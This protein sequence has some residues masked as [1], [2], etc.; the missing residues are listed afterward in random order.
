[1]DK[2]AVCEPG[3]V[4]ASD[5]SVPATP[6]LDLV[7][8]MAGDDKTAS[9]RAAAEVQRRWNA[10]AGFRESTWSS[11]DS[12]QS[13]PSEWPFDLAA[14]DDARQYLSVLTL[15]NELSVLQR[16]DVHPAEVFL[17]N[18]GPVRIYD[19]LNADDNR[20]HSEWADDEPQPEGAE[21]LS[22]WSERTLF[23]EHARVL[24]E[25]L[26]LAGWMRHDLLQEC[27]EH[28]VL[29]AA[30]LEGP[31]TLESFLAEHTGTHHHLPL[32]AGPQ[33]P[34][35]AIAIA[36]GRPGNPPTRAMINASH[37]QTGAELA[38]ET[39]R[40]TRE[41]PP[42]D[43][44]EVREWS[45]DRLRSSH[46][47]MQSFVE[48]LTA[49]LGVHRLAEDHVVRL[50]GRAVSPSLRGWVLHHLISRVRFPEWE[51][52]TLTLAGAQITFKA[53]H[54]GAIATVDAAGTRKEFFTDS[55]PA[56]LV[57]LESP[58]ALTHLAKMRVG[59]DRIGQHLSAGRAIPSRREVRGIDPRHSRRDGRETNPGDQRR[60]R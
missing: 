48:F 39:D 30:Q 54:D 10:A 40:I 42:L 36:L 50:N 52:G 1:M 28:A 56:V 49:A 17:R 19:V 57:A 60:R 22:R 4:V 53:D 12:R 35:A 3:A 29:A 18:D 20:G 26:R 44:P 8:Q 15:V 24:D 9:R 7:R 32:T 13:T 33:D 21:L 31:W 59:V 46:A 6:M 14:V 27:T 11:S 37:V 41:D 5:E 38:G 45:A 47:E 34:C 55:L 2:K 43:L 16:A 51:V 25:H 58:N 23:G